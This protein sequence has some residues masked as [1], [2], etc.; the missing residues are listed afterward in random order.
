MLRG[1]SAAGD[2]SE[3]S[4]V[5]AVNARMLRQASNRDGL[6]EKWTAALKAGRVRGIMTPALRTPKGATAVIRPLVVRKTGAVLIK[7]ILLALL[8]GG[9]L[10]L[11]GPALWG[12]SLLR[13]PVAVAGIFFIGWLTRTIFILWRRIRNGPDAE[14]LRRVGETVIGALIHAGLARKSVPRIKLRIEKENGTDLR[15]HAEGGTNYDRSIILDAIEEI[16]GPVE[17]PRY[18]IREKKK[19]YLIREDKKRFFIREDKKRGEGNRGVNYHPVPHLI[20]KKKAFAQKFAQL[21]RPQVGPADLIYTRNPNGRKELVKARVQTLSA[22]GEG[23][24]ERLE[25]WR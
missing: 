16:L 24:P 9:V 11:T 15:I 6:R 20:G 7:N 4:A 25:I 2:S 18:L 3:T 1:E 12:N 21:W 13:V 23:Q 22:T 5:A 19:R 17:N 14:S 10:M 8:A